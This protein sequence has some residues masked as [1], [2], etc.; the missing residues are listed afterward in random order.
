MID[1]LSNKVDSRS[2]V[3]VSVTSCGKLK[4]GLCRFDLYIY[5][6][7]MESISKKK[8]AHAATR[9]AYTLK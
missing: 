4:E 3:Q 2:A 5:L 6:V 8:S 7:D 1:H 9:G